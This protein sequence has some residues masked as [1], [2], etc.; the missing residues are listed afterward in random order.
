M[1]KVR[2]IV[3]DDDSNKI[4]YVEEG[5]KK[6]GIEVVAFRALVPAIEFLGRKRVDGIVTDMAFPVY[7]NNPESFQDNAGKLLLEWLI[8]EKQE[9]PVLGYSIAM[10][11]FRTE[12]PYYEGEMTAYFR[13]DLFYNFVSS[14]RD[15]K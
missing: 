7:Q 13:M 3:I 10:L 6:L 8:H 15:H 1:E 9:I 14:I 5:A 12:Y 11:N 2:I 4:R